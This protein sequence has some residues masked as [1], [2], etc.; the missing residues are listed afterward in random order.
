M[1]SKRRDQHRQICVLR[2]STE[3]LDL[4]NVVIADSNAAS[5]YTAFWAS[6]AGLSKVAGEWVF[7]EYW[8]DQ[9]QITQWRKAAAKCAEVLVP[10]KVEPNMIVGAYVSC[11]DSM[12]ALRGTG[13]ALPIALDAHLFFQR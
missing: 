2:V 8:T 9:D 4:P 5:K 7:A 6:P 10:R 3:V 11:E 1:M 13:F 12:A